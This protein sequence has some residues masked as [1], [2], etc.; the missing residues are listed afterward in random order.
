MNN[1]KIEPFKVIGIAVRTTNENEQAAKDIPVLWEKFM[2]ENVLNNIPN[3]IDN[4]IYSI[5]TDYEK[6]HTKPYTTLLGCKVESLENIPEGMIGKSFEGGDYIRF[7]AKG[8]L[9]EGLVINEWFKI[10]NMDLGRTFTADF[11]I[12]GEKAQNPSDAEVDILIAI[13]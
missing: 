2:Q 10:W 9:G 11:E 8:N 7:T 13:N 3:K 4:T 6:D 5:Y 12:Y 1:V